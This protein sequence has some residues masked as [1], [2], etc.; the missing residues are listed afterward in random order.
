M[1]IYFTGTGNSRFCAERIAARLGDTCLSSERFIRDGIA[2]ELTSETPWVF[3]SPTYAWQIPAVFASFIR[4]GTFRGS[5]DA[6]F[7]MTCGGDIGN[8]EQ[9]LNLL[10]E[11]KGFAFRGVMPV[12]MPENYIAMFNA[13]DEEKA[14]AI[15]KQAMPVMDR[16]ADLV[17]A[18]VNFPGRRI[19]VLDKLKS[20]AINSGFNR[21]FIKSNQFYA[22]DNCTGCGVCAEGC[23]LN[24]ISLK[25]GR[26]LWSDR[27][28]HCMACI[29]GCPAEA[30]EYGRK[31]IGRPRYRVPQMTE[32]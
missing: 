11:E 2:A 29:C 9:S 23:V 25:D 28:T 12:V 32:E 18:G 5:A 7:V 1:V 3:V 13:P 27:C 31:S 22:K 19:T 30:I 26:P 15:V 14:R 21:Y 10:C 17:R 16:A 6:W 24:N 8:A 20:G 4:S